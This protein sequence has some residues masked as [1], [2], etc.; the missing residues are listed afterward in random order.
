VSFG[1]KRICRA[2]R[3]HTRGQNRTREGNAV[4]WCWPGEPDD[5]TALTLSRVIGSM[6]GEMPEKKALIHHLKE[7][8]A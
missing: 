3:Q 8:S 4:R 5:A 6:K 7:A 1:L 2:W